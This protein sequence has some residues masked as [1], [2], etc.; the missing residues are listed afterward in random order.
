V[1]ARDR[2]ANK[3]TAESATVTAGF[4]AASSSTDLSPQIS[5][6]N[7]KKKKKA[8]KPWEAQYLLQL[9]RVI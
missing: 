2:N 3:K 1:V 7:K 9:S 5:K 6:L 4:S 8:K